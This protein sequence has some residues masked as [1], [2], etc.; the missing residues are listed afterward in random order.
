M[1]VE[2]SKGRLSLISRAGQHCYAKNKLLLQEWVALGAAFKQKAW[3]S[4]SFL[5]EIE[6]FQ[7]L[8]ADSDTSPKTLTKACKSPDY[9]EQGSIAR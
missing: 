2:I 5:K 1:N 7:R 8:L 6:D 3:E 9:V 4:S